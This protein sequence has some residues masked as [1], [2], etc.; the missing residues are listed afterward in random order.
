[1]IAVPLSD[2]VKVGS[3]RYGSAISPAL[4]ENVLPTRS[5]P[6]DDYQMPMAAHRHPARC[7]LAAPWTS[8]YRERCLEG[9]TKS[10][11]VLESDHIS[12]FSGLS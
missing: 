3:P 6:E 4:A 5:A 10:D 1:M 2:T 12:K 9:T 7:V 11:L 8:Q